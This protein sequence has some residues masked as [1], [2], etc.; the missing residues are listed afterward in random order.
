MIPSSFLRGYCW[1]CFSRDCVSRAMRL[2]FSTLITPWHLQNAANDQ[3]EIFVQF[4]IKTQIQFIPICCRIKSFALIDN[5]EAS[6][7]LEET[8]IRRREKMFSKP[9]WA[10]LAHCPQNVIRLVWLQFVS[11]SRLHK[12]TLIIRNVLIMSSHS[13]L[14]RRREFEWNVLKG[15]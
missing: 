4:L 3:T 8:S 14:E 13:R 2:T 9:C 5:F 1:I 6:V 7:V 11:H 10:R 12:Q 15:G